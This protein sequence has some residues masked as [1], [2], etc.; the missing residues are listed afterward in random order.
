MDKIY[1]LNLVAKARHALLHNGQLPWVSCEL[2][3]LVAFL[4]ICQ[5]HLLCTNL[6][7]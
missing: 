3:Q 4:L 5:D 7:K 6:M 1:L 2:K